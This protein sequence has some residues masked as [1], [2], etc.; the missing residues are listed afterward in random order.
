MEKERILI[1][2][3]QPH[4]IEGYSQSI[5]IYGQKDGHEVIATATSV[6]EV[7]KLLESGV[8]PTVA[9]VDNRFP[10]E[11]YG[12]KAATIIKKL[13]PKTVVISFST[14]DNLTWGAELAQMLTDIKR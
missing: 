2:D 9:L 13:S 1:A 10:F 14:D 3:D 7:K 6:G 5:E 8:K 11:G 12:E 4:N